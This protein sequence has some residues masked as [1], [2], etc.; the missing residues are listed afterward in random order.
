MFIRTSGEVND[1]TDPTDKHHLSGEYAQSLSIDQNMQ[2]GRELTNHVNDKLTNSAQ[3]TKSASGIANIL[4]DFIKENRQYSIAETYSQLL[5]GSGRNAI[6]GE[7][8]IG[9]NRAT[10]TG[11][12]PDLTRTKSLGNSEF[13]SGYIQKDR[14]FLSMGRSN[15]DF[16][17]FHQIAPVLTFDLAYF[18]NYSILVHH[19]DNNHTYVVI[20]SAGQNVGILSF[21]RNPISREWSVDAPDFDGISILA[22]SAQD[23]AFALVGCII[24]VSAL[25]VYRKHKYNSEKS[26]D[27][28]SRLQS[29]LNGCIDGHDWKCTASPESMGISIFGC[30]P[31]FISFTKCCQQHDR[32]L[33]CAKY[34]DPNQVDADVIACIAAAIFREADRVWGWGCRILG[35]FFLA[36]FIL[37]LLFLF[38]QA[39]RFVRNVYPSWGGGVGWSCLCGGP[40]KTFFCPPPDEHGNQI[41]PKQ[42]CD[43]ADPP[44]PP[45][46]IIDP[47]EDIWPCYPCYWGAAEGKG[48]MCVVWGM[49]GK[50]E[51]CRG[52]PGKKPDVCVGNSGPI[53]IPPDECL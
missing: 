22:D 46:D 53:G 31:L 13:F 23:A 35:R 39:M 9:S 4:D 7:S 2:L 50:C 36:I 49:G 51:C 48:T 1:S 8:R 47:D 28:G 44:N 12:Y 38:R 30:T 52:T 18:G 10:A 16:R 37:P 27:G 40:Q 20:E 43:G 11:H 15:A 42:L 5:N 33:W 45:P 34:N 41:N 6:E 21:V 19:P 24:Y 29:I 32:D 14:F 17:E 26:K 3:D 25:F